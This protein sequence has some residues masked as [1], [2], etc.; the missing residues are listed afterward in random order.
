[1]NAHVTLTC[2]SGG[3]QNTQQMPFQQS[4]ISTLNPPQQTQRSVFSA[5][6]GQYT[7]AQQTVPGVR[8]DLS[9]LK[10]TTRFNDLHEGLQKEIESIDAFILKQ[11]ELQAECE[12]VLPSVGERITHLPG[13]VKYC[14]RKLDAYERALENDAAAIDS[15]RDLVKSE[16]E[17]ARLSFKAI[18]SLRVPAQFHRS[19]SWNAAAVNAPK[20]LSAEDD[21]SADLVSYFSKQAD[22]MGRKLSGLTKSLREVESYLSSLEGHQSA[23]VQAA[24]MSHGRDGGVRSADEQIRELASVLRDFEGGILG[25]AGKV[26]AAREG[27]Q[28]LILGEGWN[29]RRGRG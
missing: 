6:I 21:K 8:I 22:D 5:S 26:G 12:S 18:H 13:D 15:A 16:V 29:N 19:S 1:M 3:S 9:N 24:R 2:G 23:Q 10:P 25:V 28:E 11:M 17:D 14:A 27:V 4:R 7:A 20:S